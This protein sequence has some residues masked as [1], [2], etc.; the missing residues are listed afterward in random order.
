[1]TDNGADALGVVIAEQPDVL[2]IG[3]R[4]AMTTAPALLAEAALF[5]PRT[6][7]VAQSEHGEERALLH[8]GACAVLPRL[9][10]TADVSRRLHALIVDGGA[11]TPDDPGTGEDPG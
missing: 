11:T 5:A 2:F 7:L 4:L 1:M 6:V 10:P 9:L 3:D 8:A